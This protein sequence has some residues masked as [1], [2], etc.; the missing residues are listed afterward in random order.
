MTLNIFHKAFAHLNLDLQ[1]NSNYTTF[2]IWKNSV[3]V[4]LAKKRSVQKSKWP[5]SNLSLMSYA[6]MVVCLTIKGHFM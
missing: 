3:F 4:H 6:I 5:T 2:S 1:L